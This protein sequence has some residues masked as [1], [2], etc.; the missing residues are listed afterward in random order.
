[1]NALIGPQGIP[2][3]FL[4][5]RDGRLVAHSI[6]RRTGRQFLEM[7]KAAGLE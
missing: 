7:F 5:D 6:D 4:F 1:V 2:N 3:S